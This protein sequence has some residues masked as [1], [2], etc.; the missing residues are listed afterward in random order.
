MSWFQEIMSSL[1]G[2]GAKAVTG[3]VKDVTGAARDVVGFRKDV[4]D[5]RLSE[6]KVLEYESYIKIASDADVRKYDRRVRQLEDLPGGGG[7]ESGSGLDS[8]YTERS[9]SSVLTIGLALIGAGTG[10]L[11]AY[12]LR[13]KRTGIQSTTWRSLALPEFNLPP[14]TGAG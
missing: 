12:A 13:D 6:Y 9:V 14:D 5:T 2:F 10:L 3:P 8:M 11:I 4:V 7:T 1:L